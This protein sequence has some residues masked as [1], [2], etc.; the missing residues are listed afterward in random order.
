MD[1]KILEDDLL[2]VE[3]SEFAV[4]PTSDDKY[5]LEGIFT[6]FDSMNRNGRV[7]TKKEFMPHFN[8]LKKIVESGTCVGE[9]DHPKQMETSLRNVS[10]KIVSIWLDEQNNRVMGRIKLLDTEP[11]KLA[12]AL[13]DG[14]IPLHIS[15][16]AAG[17]VTENKTVR[18]HKLFT[19]DLVDTPGF[20]NA[21]LNCVNESF[22]FSNVVNNNTTFDAFPNFAI[23]KVNKLNENHQNYTELNTKNNKNTEMNYIKEDAFNNYSEFTKKSLI[24]LKSELENHQDIL[25]SLIQQN[26]GIVEEYNSLQ[27]AESLRIL[28]TKLNKIE[29]NLSEMEDTI[30]TK[31]GNTYSIGD[32]TEYGKVRAVEKLDGKTKV[33]FDGKDLPM[34]IES[35]KSNLLN[36]KEIQTKMDRLDLLERKFKAFEKWSEEVTETVTAIEKWS[37]LVTE[38]VT[39]IENWSDLVTETVTG[40]ENWSDLVTE[41]V[42]FLETGTPIKK[43]MLESVNIDTFKDSI[44]SRL[45]SILES[46]KEVP[47]TSLNESKHLE[48]Q[49]KP[50]WLERMPSKY[51]ETWNSLKE[52]EKIK[53]TNRA[54]LYE[55][56]TES[57]IRNF[58]NNEFTKE[59]LM[60]EQTTTKITSL[61]QESLDAKRMRIV[62]GYKKNFG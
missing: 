33:F 53:I 44:Y 16:R 14:G 41:T 38:T 37:D 62:E 31:L 35:N 6:E 56:K 8:E 17:T 2:L 10:H 20:A 23:F 1:Y 9:L 3:K 4:K 46:K 28:N 30:N 5:I 24:E 13:V 55:F 61:T 54:N 29:M 15:S 47:T 40:I 59:N 52:S 32:L 36:N 27:L 26:D 50:L 49:E 18:I 12:K 11:G 21:R 22:G 58:W 51:S 39:G 7:Y 42:T 60:T 45:D 34:I 57:A 43:P 48:L 19:Y 25:E